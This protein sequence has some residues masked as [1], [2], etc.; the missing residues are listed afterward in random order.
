MGLL[1]YGSIWGLLVGLTIHATRGWTPG[2]WNLARR[3]AVLAGLLGWAVAIFP[4]MKYPAN[5]PGVGEPDS[6]GYRQTLYI[7]FVAL[8]VLGLALATAI[9]RRTGG[10]LLPALFY[11]TWALG[12]YHLM[13]PNPDPVQ[14]SEAIVRPFRALSLAGL[15]IFW[16]RSARLWPFSAATQP[17]TASG[18]P[19]QAMP[20]L[21]L[22]L[23]R[24]GRC[25][26]HPD[27]GRALAAGGK[28]SSRRGAPVA[29]RGP[30]V[31]LGSPNRDVIWVD[32]SIVPI[33][34][35]GGRRVKRL[36][37]SS[38]RGSRVRSPAV[39]RNTPGR[40]GPSAR[41]GRCRPGP[42]AAG[43]TWCGTAPWWPT[44]R[45]RST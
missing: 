39:F 32:A 18:S 40:P 23:A 4:F 8:S 30:P 9:R 6:I 41:P 17:G 2:A 3:G 13:P 38:T 42:R 24:S 16:S 1:L 33:A 35:S 15:V 27:R 14:L 10:R 26:G 36:A 22:I 7:G 25:C 37:A 5:P 44:A 45:A 20:D 19:G 21:G 29:G 31:E 28:S 43:T 12:I 34:S 11:V